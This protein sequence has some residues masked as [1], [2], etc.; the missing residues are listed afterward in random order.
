MRPTDLCLA[1]AFATAI[2]TQLSCSLSSQQCG[3]EIPTVDPPQTSYELDA[4]RATFVH[5]FE[6][7]WTDIA[8]ECEQFLGPR[9]FEA[10]QISPPNEHITGDQ[11]WVRYQPV[12]YLLN[13]R[14]GTRAE[15]EDM[16]SRCAAAGVAI[17]ADLVINH[18]AAGNGGLGVAGTQW[19]RKRHEALGYCFQHYHGPC[20]INDYG[21]A[22]QVQNCE[23]VGLPDLNTADT[24]VQDRIAAYISDLRSIGVAGFR[25]DAAKHMAPADIETI[26][27]KAGNPYVFLEVI[28]APG[29]AVQPTQYN[30]MGAVTE[31]GFSYRLAEAFLRGSIADL[32]QIASGLLP[33]T[34]AIVFTDNHD[35]QRGHGA[36]GDPLTFRYPDEHRLGA[37]FALASPY[38]YPKL[39]SSYAF[40]NS[41]QGPP[42]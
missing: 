10:V 33:S 42:D 3:G 2:P 27:A 32:E 14:G 9:G 24:Y 20:A 12:S 22:A 17:Y 21:N 19:N 35:N 7:K 30:H 8:R 11:W 4:Q 40:D 18:T 25:I 6:W 13:S 36:G 28:G 41:D 37:I 34:D 16:V 29:E 23:L 38:G 26:L 5:L 1:L 15:L 31:F 39:M